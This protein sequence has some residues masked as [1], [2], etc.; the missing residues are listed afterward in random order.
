[1]AAAIMIFQVYEF[2]TLETQHSIMINRNTWKLHATVE[3]FSP[4]ICSPFVRWCQMFIWFGL[5]PGSFFH[6]EACSPVSK[7]IIMMN[8]LIDEIMKKYLW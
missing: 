7:E 6:N 4:D 3:T 5:N 1:M 2:G 8:K